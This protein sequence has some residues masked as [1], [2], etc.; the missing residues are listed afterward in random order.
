[1]LISRDVELTYINDAGMSISLSRSGVFHLWDCR[2]QMENAISSEKVMRMD[3]E[4]F[5]NMSKD[6]RYLE[7]SG[8]IDAVAGRRQLEGQLKQTFNTGVAG[9][10]EYFHRVDN[11]RYTIRSFVEN[12]PSVV[13]NN[14]RVEFNVHLKC[15]DPFWYGTEISHSIPAAGLTF[16]NIGDSVAGFMVT[17]TGSATQPFIEN[18][19]GE[20][21]TFMSNLSGQTLRI[22]SMPDRSMVERNN[23]SAMQ[24]LSNRWQRNFFLLGIGS[25]TIRRGAAAGA[26][27]ITATLLYRP[28]YLGTF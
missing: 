5:T 15:L 14:V 10:L 8:F 7:I 21:I 23:V 4:M 12:T 1:M 6:P 28:R 22:I 20:R 18:G 24:F 16:N 3:G 19:A 2:E 26:G 13:W 27:G 11:Q 9:T 17:L 25:N